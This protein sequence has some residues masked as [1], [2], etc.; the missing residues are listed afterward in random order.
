VTA[1]PL[2]LPG[3]GPGPALAYS[4]GV[5]PA[6][7]E[8]P[9]DLE[10]LA[11][12]VLSR[13]PLALAIGIPVGVVLALFL[14]LGG[15]SRFEARVAF[16]KRG[17][18]NDILL[19]QD[20]VIRRQ[21][22]GMST[23]A[24]SVKTGS[25]LDQIREDVD[26][27]GSISA[28]S[29]R[30]SVDNPRQTELLQIRVVDEDPARAEAIAISLRTRFLESHADRALA[31]AREAVAVLSSRQA[32]ALARQRKLIELRGQL[33]EQGGL[34]DVVEERRVL[35]QSRTDL[36]RRLS[37][38]R[39]ESKAGEE[40][41]INLREMLKKEPL[42]LRFR[43]TQELH[44]QR[45]LAKREV[46]LV[47]LEK[48][49]T[50]EHPLVQAASERVRMLKERVKNGGDQLLEE[51]T[52]QVNPLR[53]Q[54]TM[55][56]S[57]V[58]GATQRAKLQA[59]ALSVLLEDVRERLDK[60]HAI[61]RQLNVI[62]QEHAD[63]QALL[64][65]HRDGLE[66]AHILLEGDASPFEVVEQPRLPLDPLPSKRPVMAGVAAFAGLGLG[67]GLILVLELRDTRIRTPEELLKLGIG[68]VLVLPTLESSIAAQAVAQAAQVIT[69]EGEGP[70]LLLGLGEG[71]EVLVLAR[72][73]S[74]C[75]T[76]P[77]STLVAT[78]LVGLGEVALPP[79]CRSGSARAALVLEQGRVP[80]A[81]VD[82]FLRYARQAGANINEAVLICDAATPFDLRAQ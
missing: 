30:I 48:R 78:P 21:E 29:R 76:G 1:Q 74:A 35:L 19:S 82:R 60:L 20:V 25:L 66:E 41:L 27:R 58:R 61:D 38:L 62:D 12:G 56:I 3:V 34:S 39:E 28:L 14:L 32:V 81:K 50:S 5:T 18:R 13:F 63:L 23:I 64:G 47:G 77:G 16:V 9:V 44:L 45:D 80:R 15:T 67:V 54:L 75:E 11:R 68:R 24:R 33:L 69:Q 79:A 73:F 8:L 37:Q 36:K 42:M 40:S 43:T 72:Q 7:P 59:R 65:A 55:E 46:I 70:L 26:F 31:N 4:E 2:Q 57:R 49:Y 52:L 51:V 10:R 22:Y 6:E 17:A 53:D 71:P